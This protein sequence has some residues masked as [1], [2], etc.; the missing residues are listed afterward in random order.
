MLE[1]REDGDNFYPTLQYAIQFFDYAVTEIGIRQRTAVL[2]ESQLGIVNVRGL[3]NAR[4]G[5]LVDLH[6]V[7]K[8]MLRELKQCLA[9]IGVPVEG[10][11]PQPDKI[12][13][14]PQ[15]REQRFGLPDGEEFEIFI[16]A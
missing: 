12:P 16:P 3:V 11:Y 15:E 14:P 1:Y 13:K 4:T 5:A 6:N 9:N 8:Y 2:L 10:F 7:G